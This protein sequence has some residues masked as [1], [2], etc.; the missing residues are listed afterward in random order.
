MTTETHFPRADWPRLLCALR[1]GEVR[2]A[3]ERCARELSVRDLALPQS[4]LAL[5]K[6]RDGALAEDYFLGEMPLARARVAVTTVDGR[7]AEGAAQILDDRASLARSIAILD[8]VLAGG[9]PGCETVEP[10]LEQ[11][12]HVLE[13][14]AAGRRALLAA[15]HVDFSLLART[16]D[17]EDDD[18]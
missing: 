15:T 16:D 14:V 18:A 5:L 3:A 8:A 2:A 13:R 11:G 4:G 10:L 9:F 1:A 7:R 12:A 6:L 17:E